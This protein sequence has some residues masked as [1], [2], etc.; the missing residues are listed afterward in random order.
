M[1]K[2]KLQVD[3]PVLTPPPQLFY[4]NLSVQYEAVLCSLVSITNTSDPAFPSQH[5]D[6]L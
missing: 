5:G 2:L 3:R 6:I 4:T 1:T